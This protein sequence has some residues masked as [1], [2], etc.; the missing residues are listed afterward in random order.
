MITF[1]NPLDVLTPKIP[2]SF[3]AEFG[4]RVTSG[5]PG[6]VSV[7]FCGARPLSLFVCGGGGTGQRA[8]SNPPSPPQTKARTPWTLHTFDT[9]LVSA[10]SYTRMSGP[11]FCPVAVYRVDSIQR[12]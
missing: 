2:F 3:F 4:V 12:L 8:V 7:G 11:V 6:S 10:C 9:A 1:L 5:A